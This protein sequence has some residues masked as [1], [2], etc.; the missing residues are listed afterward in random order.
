MPFATP[1]SSQLGT[2]FFEGYGADD[3][4][5]FTQVACLASRQRRWIGSACSRMT[6]AN[7]LWVS[8]LRSSGESWNGLARASR[9]D[10]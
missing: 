4:A 3:C 2:P 1:T 6:R 8:L 9:V 10:L 5:R 7:C